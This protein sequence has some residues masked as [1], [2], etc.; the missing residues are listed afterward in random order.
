MC[1]PA[2]AAAEARYGIPTGLLQA[3]GVVESGQ[4]DERTGQCASP[5]PGRS[6][7]RA[8]C[9]SSRPRQQAVAWVRQAQARG[10]RSIDV[11]CAQI[12][13]MY[14][15]NAFA[16]LEEAFDP[17]SNADYAARFLTELWN[18]SARRELDDGGRTLPLADA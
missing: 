7:P 18:T 2:L 11:G 6:T 14:H 17:A 5:R 10:M 8:S 16:S 4:H 1:R 9:T 13:L 12:N 15:P 3:I